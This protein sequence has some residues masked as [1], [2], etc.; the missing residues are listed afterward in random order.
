M[1][2]E[3]VPQPILSQLNLPVSDMGASLAFYRR[4][5]LEAE[6]TPDGRHA[7]LH[8]ANGFLLELDTKDFVAMWDSGYDG[9][10]GG[11]AVIGFSVPARRAVDEL[12]A[13]MTGAGYRGRQPPY[14]AAWGARYAIISDPDGNGIGLMSP[15]DP[16]LTSWPAL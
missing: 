5:G 4:L 6:V 10:T 15:V 7:A 14:D 11:G 2:A 13:S 1:P 8:L 12:S 3:Q 16:D 9:R